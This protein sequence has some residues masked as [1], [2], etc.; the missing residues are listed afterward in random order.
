MHQGKR[1]R[2]SDQRS[3]Q[4]CLVAKFYLDAIQTSVETAY[5]DLGAVF[6]CVIISSFV[7]NFGILLKSCTFIVS[8]ASIEKTWMECIRRNSAVVTVKNWT[9]TLGARKACGVVR[10]GRDRV[11]FEPSRGGTTCNWDLMW[12]EV[13]VCVRLTTW[14][15][16]TS[17][18]EQ[19]T[20]PLLHLPQILTNHCPLRGDIRKNWNDTEKISMAP[21]QGWHA[22]PEW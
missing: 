6:P 1:A 13:R 9:L 7:K 8:S 17:Q 4:A 15:K 3:G 11:C 21:A 10:R 20:K 5:G 2:S 14:L 22:F 18:P 19:N 16:P 12:F